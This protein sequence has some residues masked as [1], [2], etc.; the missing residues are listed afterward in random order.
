MMRLSLAGAAALAVCAVLAAFAGGSLQSAAEGAGKVTQQERDAS[1]PLGEP[2]QTPI[3]QEPTPEPDPESTPS[4]CCDVPDF[5]PTPEPTEPAPPTE[6]AE[7]TDAPA[8]PTATATPDGGAAGG[9]IQPPETGTGPGE[10][11]SPMMLLAT[12]F[13]IGAAVLGGAGVL[14]M[15]RTD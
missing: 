7:P 12:L 4:D 14:L 8:Q 3:K 5:S 10:G 15:K 6:V 2:E 13:A 1:V 11:T 9:G